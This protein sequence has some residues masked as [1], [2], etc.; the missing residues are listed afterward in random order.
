MSEGLE[1]STKET[2]GVSRLLDLSK[3]IRYL[4]DR[5]KKEGGFTILPL[6]FILT[7]KTPTMPFKY[8]NSWMS[9]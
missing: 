2:K 7:L 5:E 9:M 6:N 3:V 4:R 8:Y 1:G